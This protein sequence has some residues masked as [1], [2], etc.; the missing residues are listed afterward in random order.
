MF[1][2]HKGMKA[3]LAAGSCCAESLKTVNYWNLCKCTPFALRCSCH[4]HFHWTW[5]SLLDGPACNRFAGIQTC[6]VSLKGVINRDM[7]GPPVYQ[8]SSAIMFRVFIA[9]ALF[10][11][12]ARAIAP[13]LLSANTQD[14]VIT[15]N[16]SRISM[17][18]AVYISITWPLP[19]TP[20]GTVFWPFVN[21]SQ[22]GA[23]VTCFVQLPGGAAASDNACSIELPLPYSGENTL[24]F[25]VFE[26]GAVLLTCPARP[27]PPRITFVFL[28]ILFP[29]CLC[30]SSVGR[31]HQRV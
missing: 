7:G 5:I 11:S 10:L 31:R 15:V 23:F 12:C 28:L 20:S 2:V 6:C 13:P 27:Q 22:W 25:A 19:P 30:R 21:G 29:R 14:F 8:S 18:D 3:C 9:A 4:I 16:S 1:S 26:E 24:Q 17:G